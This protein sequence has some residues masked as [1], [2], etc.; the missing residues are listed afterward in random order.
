MAN[1]RKKRCTNPACRKTFSYVPGGVIH[2]P[3]CEEGTQRGWATFQ[4]GVDALPMLHKGYFT[5]RLDKPAAMNKKLAAI[6]A[7]RSAWVM[8]GAGPLGLKEAKHIMDG[9]WNGQPFVLEAQTAGQAL[10]MMREG[11][12]DLSFRP[13]RRASPRQR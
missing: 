6:K 3:W 8:T 9:V 11:N 4:F 5:V 13:E 7:L 1:M 12:V 10:L 2:C